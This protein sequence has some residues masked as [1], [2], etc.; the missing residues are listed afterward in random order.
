MAFRLTIASHSGRLVP[1]VSPLTRPGGMFGRATSVIFSGRDDRGGITSVPSSGGSVFLLAG[2]T[3]Q[4][5]AFSAEG[6]R[7]CKPHV[8]PCRDDGCT[9]SVY[10]TS[11]SLMLSGMRSLRRAGLRGA[12]TSNSMILYLLGEITQRFPH[13]GSHLAAKMNWQVWSRIQNS[14]PAPPAFPARTA[15]S[16]SRSVPFTHVL[17]RL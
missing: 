12:T 13:F 5:W 4:K 1:A 17:A 2:R 9:G 7:V 8:I 14:N 10:M 16:R 6:Q 3:L 11:T 15:P